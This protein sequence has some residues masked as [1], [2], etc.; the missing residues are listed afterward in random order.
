MNVLKCRACGLAIS[1]L[2]LEID[3]AFEKIINPMTFRNGNFHFYCFELLWEEALQTP[4]K[5]PFENRLDEYLYK[6]G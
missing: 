4:A 2:E 1:I 5:Q 6:Y 3:E